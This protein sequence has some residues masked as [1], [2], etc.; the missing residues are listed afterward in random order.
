MEEKK[1]P[2]AAGTGVPDFEVWAYGLASEYD[3]KAAKTSGK[4]QE[5]QMMRR[6]RELSKDSLVYRVPVKLKVLK[7]YDRRRGN[8]TKKEVGSMHRELGVEVEMVENAPKG[9]LNNYDDGL[10]MS[11]F[12]AGTQ[13]TLVYCPDDHTTAARVSRSCEVLK[14]KP[15]TAA[16]SANAEVEAGEVPES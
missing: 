7:V 6:H 14:V 15:E 5:V 10:G 16:T 12:T 4:V 2:K 8:A 13:F 1:M 9:I 3:L 11:A